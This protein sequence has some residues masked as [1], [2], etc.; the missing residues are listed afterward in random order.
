[1]SLRVYYR[2]RPNGV[3]ETEPK[4]DD[5]KLEEVVALA[6]APLPPDDGTYGWL[7]QEEPSGL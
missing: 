1:M 2:I 5:E 6:R 4:T 3:V 7:P